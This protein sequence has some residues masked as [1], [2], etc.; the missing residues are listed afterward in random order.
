MIKN[1]TLRNIVY[2]SLL[3]G[4]F[5]I[6]EF[7]CERYHSYTNHSNVTTQ[8]SEEESDK[9]NEH[10]PSLEDFKIVLGKERLEEMTEYDNKKL[11]DFWNKENDDGKRLFY[12]VYKDSSQVI[13]NMRENSARIEDSFK[14]FDPYSLSSSEIKEYETIIPWKIIPANFNLKDA[15]KTMLFILHY[16]H[17]EPL[18]IQDIDIFTGNIFLKD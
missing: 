9:K 2:N 10:I 14:S 16:I 4:S 13:R 15:D 17:K 1:K 3:A 11:V 8:I 12:S 6:G 18:E 5:L 7:A